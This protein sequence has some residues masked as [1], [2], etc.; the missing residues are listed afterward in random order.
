MAS[1][2]CHTLYTASQFLP[3]QVLVAISSVS[4]IAIVA[5]RDIIVVLIRR[6]HEDGER[7]MLVDRYDIIRTYGDVNEQ[8][9]DD[10][11][12]DYVICG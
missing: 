4:G 12:I 9:T 10:M 2:I 7:E 1:L 3:S 5:V 6:C 11:D 8:R